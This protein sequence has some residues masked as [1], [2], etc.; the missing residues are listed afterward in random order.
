MLIHVDKDLGVIQGL[1]WQS[2]LAR[3]EYAGL[4][5][6]IFALGVPVTPHSLFRACNT[7]ALGEPALGLFT[8]EDKASKSGVLDSARM[9]TNLM[10][11]IHLL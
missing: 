2:V 6:S 4:A 11:F 7:C 3:K 5:L 1:V 9:S 8:R 10:S